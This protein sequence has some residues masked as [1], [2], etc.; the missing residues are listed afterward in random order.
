MKNTIWKVKD[1]KKVNRPWGNYRKLVSKIEFAEGEFF[2]G[3]FRENDDG[4]ESICVHKTSNGYGVS[5][6]GL[7]WVNNDEEKQKALDEIFDTIW[8]YKA[9]T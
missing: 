2:I 8:N 1:F 5:K 9:K 4:R 3:L 7:Y 6:L